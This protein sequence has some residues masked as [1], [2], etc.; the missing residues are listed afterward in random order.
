[1][2]GERGNLIFLW[3]IYYKNMPTLKL[4]FLVVPTYNTLTLGVVDTSTY[5][6]DPP[7]VTSPTIEITPPGFNVAIIPFDVNSYNTFTSSNLGITAVGINQPLPDGIYHIKYSISPAYLNFVEKSIMRTDRIQERFD[8]AF[9]R[10]DMMECDRA[11]KTQSKVELTS[12][13]FF[14]QGSIA[15]A[16]NC[17]LV[18]SNK[19]YNQAN[20]MLDTFINSDC[21]CSGN[22]YL[23]N[24]Y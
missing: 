20:K 22:N 2:P 24:F 9:M 7:V 11:I 12:I 8:E 21:G 23:L 10:L 1:M 19:L 15:A 17:A 3:H 14:I 18:D 5:L 6:T 4:D 16:N 13:Y